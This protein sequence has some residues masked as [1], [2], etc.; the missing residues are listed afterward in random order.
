MPSKPFASAAG[1]HSVDDFSEI[2]SWNQSHGNFKSG[3]YNA[4]WRRLRF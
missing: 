4:A 2:I 1:G 3:S